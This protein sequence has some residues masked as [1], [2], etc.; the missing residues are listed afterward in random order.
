MSKTILI[1]DDQEDI[2]FSIKSLLEK[3]GYVVYTAQDGDDCLNKLKDVKVDLVLLDIMM[4]GIPV[5]ELI[6]QIK[7]PKIA[8]LSAV[9]MSDLEKDELMKENI[10]A[11]IQKPPTN[12]QLLQQINKILS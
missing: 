8:F 12:E 10:V 7:D 2:R 6:E 5:R 3:H 1:V 11:Y 4:P 9:R